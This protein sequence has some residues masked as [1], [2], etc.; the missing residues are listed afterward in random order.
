MFIN[1]S[2]EKGKKQNAD[3]GKCAYGNRQFP[4]LSTDQV[5]RT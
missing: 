5:S 4:Q 1:W 3:C 2:P